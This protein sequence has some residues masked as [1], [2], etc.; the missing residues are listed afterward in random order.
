[1][2]INTR[3]FTLEKLNNINT[4][5]FDAFYLGDPFAPQYPGNLCF[6]FEDLRQAVDILK[7]KGKKVY[8]STFSVPRNR[9]LPPIEKLLQFI[10]N[11]K[12]PIDAIE[13]HNTGVL[14]LVREIMP[15]MPVHMGCLSNIYTDSTVQLL[16]E[17]GVTRVSPGYELTLDEFDIIKNKCKINV[18]V[19]VHGRMVLGVSEECPALWWHRQQEQETEENETNNQKFCTGIIE[20]HSDKMD[21]TVRGR[22]TMS[23]KDVCM[24]E[25]IPLLIE[26]GFQH[27]RIDTSIG[28]DR[29]FN[30]VGKI[31]REAFDLF[32]KDKTR[33]HE[34]FYK[35][36][37]GFM[38]EFEEITNHGLCN[39]YYF[40][41]SGSQYVKAEKKI[42]HEDR[43]ILVLSDKEEMFHKVKH[44]LNKKNYYKIE[45]LNSFDEAYPIV[46]KNEVDFVFYDVHLALKDGVKK[47]DMMKEANSNVPV[48]VS[49]VLHHPPGG[50]PHKRNG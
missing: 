4:A 10:K 29:Y 18:E 14:K 6:E 15:Q 7:Q 1:M 2:E 11:E 27:F 36:L 21:L 43:K 13:T 50:P 22:T 26:K 3:I 12:L 16:K 33:E 35:K 20:L 32:E 5:F 28:D 45:Y 49:A 38:K 24:L 44:L 47:L 37:P 46:Q 42:P 19:L 40:G 48:V 34:S 25:Y 8:V 17:D 23:G 30:T 9:D 39:G 31:Y 41:K